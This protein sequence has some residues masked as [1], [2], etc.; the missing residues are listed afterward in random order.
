M[1][2][3]GDVARDLAGL[4]LHPR[5]WWLNATHTRCPVCGEYIGV[6]HELQVHRLRHGPLAWQAAIGSEVRGGDGR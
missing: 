6:G 4:A 5:Q 2:F 3:W 1:S